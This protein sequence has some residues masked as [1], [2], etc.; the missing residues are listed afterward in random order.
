MNKHE[1]KIL[2]G[3]PR[4]N[5]YPTLLSDRIKDGT[6]TKDS[7]VRTPIATPNMICCMTEIKEM[8]DVYTTTAQY[9]SEQ[10]AIDYIDDRL[11]NIYIS[12]KEVTIYL[13][14]TKKIIYHKQRSL[15][16]RWFK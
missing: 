11:R 5:K 15:Y 16:Q 1:R 8:F 2:A 4:W 3:N 9:D 6:I 7:I 10:S 13:L 14:P 12:W